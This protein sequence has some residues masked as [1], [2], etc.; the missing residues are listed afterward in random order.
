METDSQLAQ[1][2]TAA[3]NAIA[4]YERCKD[5]PAEVLILNEPKARATLESIARQIR[6]LKSIH[7]SHVSDTQSLPLTDPRPIDPEIRTALRGMSEKQRDAILDDPSSG[8]LKAVLDAPEFLSG[9]S[10][11]RQSQL[12]EEAL[13]RRYGHLWEQ[14]EIEA[15]ALKDLQEFVN[16]AL[17]SVN[18]VAA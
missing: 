18:K 9:I 14:Q 16:N 10:Q 8:A 11:E 1:L 15:A 6:L 17:H 2:R 12:A 5:A 3:E 13:V 7:E 4:T